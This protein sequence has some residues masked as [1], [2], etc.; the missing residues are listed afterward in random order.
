MLYISDRPVVEASGGFCRFGGMPLP[1]FSRNA[2][3]GVGGEQKF[4][5]DRHAVQNEAGSGNRKCKCC[6]SWLSHWQNN[7]RTNRRK[8]VYLGCGAA[9][10]HGAH[11]KFIDMDKLRKFPKS[12]LIPLCAKHNNP[13][14]KNLFYI[15]STVELVKEKASSKCC[16]T[17]K[18]ANKN[19]NFLMKV[20]KKKVQ[21][22]C[23]CGTVSEHYTINTGS[24]RK[25]CAVTPCGKP[26]REFA[27]MRGEDGRA[28]KGLWIAPVC[29]KHKSSGD[30]VFIEGPA[31]LVPLGPGKE[32]K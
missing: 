26:T 30:P 4:M 21:L 14:H 28:G 19:K 32:C 8:C 25:R 7:A 17:E 3:F 16:K 5:D 29:K 22:S 11:V 2:L 23:S 1:K 6:G 20:I 9:P 10:V 31:W 18:K 27:V 15:S 13:G 12:W 24:K